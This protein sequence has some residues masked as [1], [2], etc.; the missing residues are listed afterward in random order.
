MPV[1]APPTIQDLPVVYVNGGKQGFLMEITPR[2]FDHVLTVTYG[3][4][5]TG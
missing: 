5:T 3:D 1:Y 4:I 2:A